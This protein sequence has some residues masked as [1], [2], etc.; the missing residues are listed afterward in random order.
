MLA[1]INP[2]DVVRD[3]DDTPDVAHFELCCL[4][5]KLDHPLEIGETN[6][7]EEYIQHPHS[8]CFFL[9]F[10]G[11]PQLETWLNYSQNIVISLRSVCCM[12]F[13]LLV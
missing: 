7:I 5:A 8:P 3:W 4:I 1:F 2:T 9:K 11:K 13:L 12:V 6:A 10:V